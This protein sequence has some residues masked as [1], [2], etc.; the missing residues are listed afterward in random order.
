MP[1][2]RPRQIPPHDDDDHTDRGRIHAASTTAPKTP[3]TTTAA[4]AASAAA[5]TVE[6]ICA[7]AFA[8]DHNNDN[9][10]ER[11]DARVRFLLILLSDQCEH[12]W[13]EVLRQVQPFTRSL[14]RRLDPHNAADL[15]LE[16]G[17]EIVAAFRERI[18][19]FESQK[20]LRDRLADI[21]INV[22]RKRLRAERRWRA[23]VAQLID[24]YRRGRSVSLADRLIARTL[25]ERLR[26]A[27]ESLE[28]TDQAIVTM[29]IADDMTFVDIAACLGHALSPD[30]VADHYR[31]ALRDLRD[32]F[33]T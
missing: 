28:P 22:Y 8:A 27:V 14:A 5:L 25:L 31:A 11:I 29:R 17:Q 26:R 18:F 6:Q 16:L 15:A 12:A 23:V 13:L 33:E 9:D 10:D 4:T 19:N 21:A 2:K 1:T 24:D 20:N 30:A 7:R 32:W 3:A